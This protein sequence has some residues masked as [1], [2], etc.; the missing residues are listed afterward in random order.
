[1]AGLDELDKFVRK[2]VSLWQSGCEASLHVESK[3]GNAFVS[4]QLGLGQAQPH[5]AKGQHVG[6]CR[7]GSPSKQRR[8]ERREAERQERARAEEADA[9]G[10]VSDTSKLNAEKAEIKM[11]ESVA[12]EVNLDDPE[13]SEIE[14]D[15]TIEYILR[16]EAHE[17]CKNYDV[18]EA[19]EV[20]FD[21][22]LNDLNI[23]ENDDARYIL[24]QKIDKHEKVEKVDDQEKERNYVLNYKVFIR[25]CEAAK[26]VVLS[27]KNKYKF[28]DLAFRSA[29]YGIVRVRIL[30]VQEV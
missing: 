3:A 19:I 5:L 12:E 26:S 18:I 16:I 24:V 11:E 2:F 23:E 25:N 30:E 7:G 9:V 15:E 4:L 13:N 22:A 8:K 17:K 6:G 27:W 1:M 28:D 20:N 14:S 10:K 29:V 21:G